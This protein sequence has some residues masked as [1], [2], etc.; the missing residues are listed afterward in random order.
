LETATLQLEA[1]IVDMHYGEMPLPEN[2]YFQR[3]TL[4]L[5]IWRK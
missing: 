5:T 4:E 1:R 3:F 2:S